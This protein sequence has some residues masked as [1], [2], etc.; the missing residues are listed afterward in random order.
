MSTPHDDRW[1]E[2]YDDPGLRSHGN[3][4]WFVESEMNPHLAHDSLPLVSSIGRG[5]RGEGLEAIVHENDSEH[6]SFSVVSTLTG[7]AYFT[8]PNLTTGFIEVTSDPHNKVEGEVGHMNVRHVRG[9]EVREYDVE[10][11]PGAHGSRMYLSDITQTWREDETYTVPAGDLIHYGRKEYQDK[12]LPRNGDIVAFTM[13]KGVE[14]LFGFG[15]VEEVWNDPD[16]TVVFTS[17]TRFGIE[18]PHMSENGN[19]VVDGVETD[20]P[21]TGP[22]GPQGP[23]GEPGMQGRPGLPGDK[24]EPGE[25]GPEG[26]KGEDGMDAKLELG[27]V[28]T[29]PPGKATASTTYDSETNTTTLHLGIP[30]GAAGKAISIQGGIWTYD[31]LPPYD[32]TP[33]NDAFIV[34]D[35][36]KQ[37]DLYIRGAYPS[38]AELGGPWTVVEDWQGKPGAGSHLLLAPYFMPDAIDDE[39]RIPASEGSLAFTPSDYLTDGAVVIDTHLHVGILSSTEDDSG[40]YVVTTKGMLSISWPNVSDKPFKDVDISDSSM[41][42]IVDGK[43][44]T[45]TDVIIDGLPRPMWVNA[46]VIQNSSI[47]YGA[48]DANKK[49]YA[50]IYMYAP[51]PITLH[52]RFF[53]IEKHMNVVGGE[54]TSERVV[55]EI[56]YTFYSPSPDGTK[57]TIAEYGIR[58]LDMGKCECM[59]IGITCPDRDLGWWVGDKE[60][61]IWEYRDS[62]TW[63]N[64]YCKP[65]THIGKGLSIRATDEADGYKYYLDVNPQDLDLDLPLDDI[66]S[67]LP[68]VMVRGYYNEANDGIGSVQLWAFSAKQMQLPVYIVASRFDED[69]TGEQWTP[70]TLA[71]VP[72]TFDISTPITVGDETWYYKYEYVS[73]DGVMHAEQASI[74]VGPDHTVY[75]YDRL[76]EWNDLANRPFKSIGDGLHVVGSDKVLEAVYP[77]TDFIAAAS[78]DRFDNDGDPQFF[79][80]M[81]PFTAALDVRLRLSKDGRSILDKVMLT[82]S[83][84]LAL[85]SGEVGPF[86]TTITPELSE[87]DRQAVATGF[88]AVV[89]HG[90][91]EVVINYDPAKSVQSGALPDVGD[92]DQVTDPKPGE[93]YVIDGHIWVWTI[94]PDGTGSWQD[95]GSIQGPKGDKGDSGEKGDKG[96][97]LDI[98]GVYPDLDDLLGKNPNPSVGDV[99]YV[100]DKLYVWDGTQ[101]VEMGNQIGPTINVDGSYPTL[102]DLIAAVTNPKPG[103]TYLVGDTLYVWNGTEW[104]PNGV[105]QGPAGPKGE[106][107]DPGEKGDTGEQGEQGIRGA[108]W[109]TEEQ[110]PGSLSVDDPNSNV[111]PVIPDLME[112]DF[113]MSSDGDLWK[114]YGMDDARASFD[115]H[116]QGSLRGPAGKSG[117]GG[118]G[119]LGAGGYSF[120]PS[121]L[122]HVESG[123]HMTQ[124]YSATSV[125]FD[126]PFNGIPN[127]VV[128]WA[129][130]PHP[131]GTISNFYYLAV[132]SVT[133]T[134][135]TVKV[136]TNQSY[137]STNPLNKK[138]CWIASE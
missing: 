35:G 109:Y 116:Y 97:G 40:D 98:S 57:G 25:P 94:G 22:I 126:E 124:A 26:P 103:D 80:V 127:V 133:N 73:F 39:I 132:L 131:S 23:P 137:G 29:L 76:E 14:K 2:P 19:W 46:E 96:E 65:F 42:N 55:K 117:S 62:T 81:E 75:A 20:I 6:F 5:P 110:Y 15:T 123:T 115:W 18:L 37:F 112:G 53:A 129:E 138:I 60:T 21:A 45:K 111:Y 83:E 24:G 58:N 9:S 10:L 13:H 122:S 128:S 61:V 107:G 87:A 1:G 93:S 114:W 43:L 77:E 108:T 12:P 134:Y 68:Y 64:I 59:R 74:C 44:T 113:W 136:F 92:L 91:G 72:Y 101:W 119:G 100:G 82:G 49:L 125:Y 102:N 79:I 118:L 38:H 56:D 4:A 63:N 54:V 11:P 99:V 7:E 41:L 52:I 50:H 120:E 86:L 17:R 69:D 31:T 135:F 28:E 85:R 30:E 48:T 121:D 47:S 89:I 90:G 33:I 106:K 104:V 67:G 105:A 70:T 3:S 36:D 27:N 34:Y 84:V 51:E 8:S 88:K 71:S 16:T 95:G 32:D 78:F 130:N 66:K